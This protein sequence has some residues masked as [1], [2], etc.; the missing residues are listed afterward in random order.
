MFDFANVLKLLPAVGPVI[1]GLPEFRNIYDV[2]VATF[3]TDDQAALKA[4]YAKLIDDNEE[5]HRR[6]QE[7]LAAAVQ[8]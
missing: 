7:K 5:G 2:I 4:A 3:T 6:L 8:R 1:A